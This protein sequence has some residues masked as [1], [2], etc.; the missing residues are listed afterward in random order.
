MKY[1]S[2]TSVVLAIF[3]GAVTS[4]AASARQP[5]AL[6]LYTQ[7]FPPLQFMLDGKPQGY[8]IEFVTALVQDAS[9]TIPLEIKQ[10]H[11]APWNRAI[12][13][14]IETENTLFFSVSRTPEREDKFQWIGQV[15]PYKVGLYRLA[16]GPQVNAKNLEQLKGYR[17]GSQVGSSFSELLAKN[18]LDQVI[19]VEKGKEA[20]R[21][22]HTHRVDFAPMVEAS[23]HYRMQEYGYDPHEFVK[24]MNV[25]PLCQDLWLVTGNRTSAS[26]VEALK[27]SYSKLQQQAYLDK[28]VAEFTPTS[29]IMLHYSESKANPR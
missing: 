24:V 25:T 8:V 10:I 11:F 14:T 3:L 21:L 19:S 20:I 12:K 5:V 6:E 2:N 9:K 13:T 18:G 4:A 27:S 28:L 17:F 29:A 22:L 23:F 16:S 26:V 15:S 7:E 1:I